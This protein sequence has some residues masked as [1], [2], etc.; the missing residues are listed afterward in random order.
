[1]SSRTFKSKLFTEITAIPKVLQP[2]YFPSIDGLRAVAILSVILSHALLGIG[3]DYFCYALGMIGVQIFFVISG[4]LITT[5]LLK[6]K[7]VKGTIS[8]R[9]F[10]IRRFLRIIPV[11]YLYLIIIALLAIIF[12]FDL[13]KENFIASALYFKNLPLGDGHDRFVGH[14][15]TLS[16]EEQFYFVFPILLLMINANKYLILIIALVVLIPALEFFGYN[17]IGIFY[18]NHIIHLITFIFIDF[19]GN[20]TVAIL[21]GSVL[22][23]LVFKGL[24]IVESIKTNYVLSLI[25]FSVAIGVRVLFVYPVYNV[26]IGIVLFSFLISYTILLNLKEDNLFNRVLRNP[27]MIKIGILS[28][29]LYIWQALFTHNMIWKTWFRYS[30][31]MILNL[32]MLFLVSFLSY[33][34]YEKWFLKLKNKF[35]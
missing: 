17:K 15:W 4:F 16:I 10:Y 3:I 25:V 27:I 8:L 24:I 13:D 20:G 33:N 29:S 2:S 30:D 34:Y 12:K 26:G 6:E 28:Y 14:F 22:S 7:V 32:P 19:F 31:S 35:H 5:L 21:F 9:K 11:A 18:S 23:I 1:M